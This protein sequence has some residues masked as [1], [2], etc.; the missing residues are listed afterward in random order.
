MLY[1]LP[2]IIVLSTILGKN[3]AEEKVRR[4]D[5]F[6]STPREIQINSLLVV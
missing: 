5:D 6:A 4:C 1:M 2:N 3:E